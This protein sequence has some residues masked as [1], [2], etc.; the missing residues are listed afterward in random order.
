[1]A[2]SGD[3]LSP[4]RRKEMRMFINC[5]DKKVW[6]FLTARGEEEI[7]CHQLRK[8]TGQMRKVLARNLKIPPKAVTQVPKNCPPNSDYINNNLLNFHITQ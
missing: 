2:S 1:M 3:Q 8:L 4:R 5:Q 7:I 6:E